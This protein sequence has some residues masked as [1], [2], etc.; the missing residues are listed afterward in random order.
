MKEDLI[1]KLT[2]LAKRNIKFNLYLD[3]NVLFSLLG[4]H[5]NPSNE[6][7]ISLKK[8]I[9][10]ISN[11]INVN[12]YVLPP[13]LKEALGVLRY[14]VEHLNGIR[15]TKNIINA[16]SNLALSGFN[17]KIFDEAQKV[18]SQFS[19]QKYFEPYIKNFITIMRAH[20]IELCNEDI[21]KYNMDPRVL[22]DVA[23]SLAYEKRA[24]KKT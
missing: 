24:F 20:G 17:K 10:K 11:K 4:L 2:S 21:D 1:Q 16:S 5:E 13:T 19:V 3:T 15:F 8:L 23:A 22:D 12:L 14:N 9:Q 6:A 18:G 7:A